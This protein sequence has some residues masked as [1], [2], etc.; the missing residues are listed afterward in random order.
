MYA[1]TVCLSP[2]RCFAFRLSVPSPF[3]PSLEVRWF[4][5]GAI[6][7]AV[8]AWFDEAPHAPAARRTDRY[9]L[10]PEQDALGLKLREG[11]FEAK[12]RQHR[13][14]VRQFSAQAWGRVEH[15]RKWSFSLEAGPVG[16]L[17]TP[18]EAW[19]SVDKTRRL[20]TYGL[21]AEGRPVVRAPSDPEPERGCGLELTEVEAADA[22]WWSLGFEAFGPESTLGETF[23]AVVARVFSNPPPTAL[24]VGSSFGYPCWF[25]RLPAP[26]DTDLAHP[27]RP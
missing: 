15:W 19:L 14:G 23:D 26:S 12:R 27:H 5:P 8:A 1:F 24:P 16:E 2:S 25:L 13:L 22:R 18:D 4:F 9:L 3:Y 17:A 11:R 7:E 6:P 20:R 10:L 21:D